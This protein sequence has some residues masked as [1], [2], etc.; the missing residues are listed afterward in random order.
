MPLAVNIL[1]APSYSFLG[2][3]GT[4]RFSYA[5]THTFDFSR[6][7]LK[8]EDFATLKMKA[9]SSSPVSLVSGTFDVGPQT[10]WPIRGFFWIFSERQVD[11]TAIIN[12]YQPSQ[13]S[14][15]AT[16]EVR[17]N[18]WT[19]CSVVGPE[20][21]P[22]ASASL[23]IHMTGL[24]SGY[25]AYMAAPMIYAPDAISANLFAG[26]V[27]AR[28]PQYLREVD[29]L[30]SNPDFPLLRFIDVCF[31]DANE[32]YRIWDQYQYIPPELGGETQTASLLDPSIASEYVL[33][34]W[35]RILGIKIYDPSLNTGGTSWSKFESTLSTWAEWE[36]EPDTVDVGTTAEWYEIEN[37]DPVVVGLSDLIRWQVQTAYNGLRGGTLIAL[38]ESTKKVLSGTKFVTILK[39]DGGDPWKIRIQTKQSET[40]NNPTVGTSSSAITDIIANAIPAGYE[41]VHEVVAG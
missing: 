21:F 18:E 34:W 31:Y 28:L 19:L 27:W 13:V 9:A 39:R 8:Y 40:P 32:A 10:E 1:D 17:A 11:V 14:A 36:T 6:E 33:R 30:Q 23:G 3:I 2:S 29:E 26:E 22:G 15:S 4:W 7:K 16:Y 20:A 37:Y 38:R 12:V 35:A 5:Q 24:T 25:S 41:V